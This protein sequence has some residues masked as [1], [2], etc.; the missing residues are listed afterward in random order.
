MKLQDSLNNMQINLEK[1]ERNGHGDR[2]ISNSGILKDH[3]LIFA[4]N[5][6]KILLMHFKII[7]ILKLVFATGLFSLEEQS[8]LMRE[9]S[10]IQLILYK[11]SRNSL[12]KI[13]IKYY[14]YLWE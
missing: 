11:N 8:L 12:N 2:K 3:I 10:A 4:F 9:I 14:F 13:F 5:K 7:K 6:I 1:T